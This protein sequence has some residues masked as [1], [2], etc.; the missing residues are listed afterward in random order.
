MGRVSKKDMAEAIVPQR[1]TKIRGE[2]SVKVVKTNEKSEIYDKV[3]VK[4]E[5]LPSDQIM[6]AKEVVGDNTKFKIK[7]NTS[8]MI[9]NPNDKKFVSE[10]YRTSSLTSGS[11]YKMVPVDRKTFEYFITFLKNQDIKYYNQAQRG[12]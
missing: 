10:S 4:Q 5:Y 3:G 8:G 9:W 2:K 6:A 11:P 7:C 12:I 1:G